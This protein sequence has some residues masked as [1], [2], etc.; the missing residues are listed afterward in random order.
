MNWPA[1]D[2]NALAPLYED[3]D[4]S[5]VIASLDHPR[6]PLRMAV[7]SGG[8]SVHGWFDAAELSEGEQLRW[9]RHAVFLGHDSKLWLKWQWVRAP[10]G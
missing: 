9:F 8:K 7:Y 3:N 10:G 6:C 4:S 1:S 5:N 2:A